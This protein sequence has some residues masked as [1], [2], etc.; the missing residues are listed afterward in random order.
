MFNNRHMSTSRT[1]LTGLSLLV[2]A[3]GVA[4][5]HSGVA[6]LSHGKTTTTAPA[7][8][9]AGTGSSGGGD[10]AAAPGSGGQQLA[11]GQ[12][13][14]GGASYTQALEFSRCM[15]SH[16]LPDFPDP[17]T[18]GGGIGIHIRANGKSDL[19]PNSPQFQAAQ[20]AC[21]SI[22]GTGPLAEK[23]GAKPR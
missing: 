19:N 21:Q 6:S 20:K 11:I 1:T 3:C 12:L 5:S 7:V 8:A 17:R 13:A 14:I 23:S 10:T 22:M 16:G 4:P 9:P 2:A 18:H 15:R